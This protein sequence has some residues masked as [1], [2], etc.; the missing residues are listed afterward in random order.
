METGKFVKAIEEMSSEDLEFYK[1]FA[2]FMA[3]MGLTPDK[4]D[5]LVEVASKWDTLISEIN[6]LSNQ[7]SASV[8][9]LSMQ[10]ESLRNDIKSGNVDKKKTLM[11]D[12]NSEV[13]MLT[14]YG[15]R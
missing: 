4:L 10:V 8:E 7:M 14:P 2:S 5:K 11:D 13:E 3:Y 1:R 12:F 6:K 15:K 9:S